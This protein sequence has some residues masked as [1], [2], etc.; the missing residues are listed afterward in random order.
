MTDGGTTR[1]VRPADWKREEMSARKRKL[2][3][4]LEYTPA[5]FARIRLG[6]LPEQMEDKWFL[7]FEGDTLHM[8]RSWTGY[9]N[10]RVRFVPTIDGGARATQLLVN[11][12][13][14]QYVGHDDETEA[15]RVEFL[16]NV[17]LAHNGWVPEL[18]P[19]NEEAESQ[20]ALQLWGDIGRAL[21]GQGP[22]PG[23]RDD[24]IGPEPTAH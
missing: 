1:P 14:G 24:S 3:L 4:D 23:F 13:R 2:A 22:R 16:L 15:N 19:S 18:P 5:Q 12:D 6:L 8:H 17:L 10:Y 20:L 21:M 11:D 7:Y 9:E